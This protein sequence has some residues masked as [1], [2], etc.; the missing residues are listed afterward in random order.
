[1]N[2]ANNEPC[3]NTQ[4]EIDRDMEESRPC[5]RCGKDFDYCGCPEYDY[6][7]EENQS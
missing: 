5:R 1:M 7:S 6:T 3:R 4:A 2:H